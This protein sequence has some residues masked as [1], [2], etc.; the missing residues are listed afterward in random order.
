MLHRFL[1]QQHFIVF[2]ASHTPHTCVSPEE[3]WKIRKTGV[4]SD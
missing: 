4:L 1:F 2:P 3:Y